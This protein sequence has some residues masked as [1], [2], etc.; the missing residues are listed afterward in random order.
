MRLRGLVRSL[1]VNDWAARGWS[2]LRV[3]HAGNVDGEDGDQSCEEGWV[4]GACLCAGD[5]EA[6]G[7]EAD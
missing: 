4:N 7:E 5:E 3:V 6:Q 1:L 2:C